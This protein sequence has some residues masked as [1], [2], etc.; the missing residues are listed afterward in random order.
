M[1]F[2]FEQMAVYQ[3]AEAWAEMA[4]NFVLRGR[5]HSSYGMLDQLSR[6][7]SS[8]PQN[9]AEGVGKWGSKDRQRYFQIA[10]GS[11]YECVPILN[12][13]QRKKIITPEERSRAYDLLDEMGAML[14]T[15]IK[16]AI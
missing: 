4:E 13:L 14:T 2:P 6:A 11:V 8:V 1:S 12:F 10:R 9:V 5:K 3:K 15:L 16:R 7:A